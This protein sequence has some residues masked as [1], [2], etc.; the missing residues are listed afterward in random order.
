MEPLLGLAHR[1]GVVRA[2]VQDQGGCA[3]RVGVAERRELRHPC[4]VADLVAG[5][6]V[7]LLGGAGH[8][9]QVDQDAA[10]YDGGEQVAAGGEPAGQ[11]A[12]VAVAGERD[13]CR[14]DEPLGDEGGDR[15]QD[16]LFVGLAPGAEGGRVERLAV[17]VA[18]AHV[19]RQDRPAP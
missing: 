18:G 13:P 16:V 10:R 14:V 4:R 19:R 12:A 6:Q 11:I 8:A 2:A 7:A 17:A 5:D 3:D 15:L 1:A 9:L